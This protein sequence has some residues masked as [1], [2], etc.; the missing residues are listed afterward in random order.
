MTRTRW[1]TSTGDVNLQAPEVCKEPEPTVTV[2]VTFSYPRHLQL[3][4]DQV[5]ASLAGRQRIRWDTPR[6]V[7]AQDGSEEYRIAG[8]EILSATSGNCHS[9]SVTL[10]NGRVVES[11]EIGGD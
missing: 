4:P 9:V 8:T 11:S 5:V 7:A 2:R 3:S 6:R 1:G 10:R